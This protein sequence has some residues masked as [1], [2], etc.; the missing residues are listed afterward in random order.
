MQGGG[1]IVRLCTS[2]NSFIEYSVGGCLG[3]NGQQPLLTYSGGSTP[4]ATFTTTLS[5]GLAT[6]NSLAA[7]VFSFRVRTGPFELDFLGAPNC[8]AWVFG[9]VATFVT[10]PGGTAS[11]PI[12]VPGNFTSCL[13]LWNR[14][15]V[16]DR[17]SGRLGITTSNFGRIL[18]RQLTIRTRSEH[19]LRRALARVK[20]ALDE[21]WAQHR[22]FGGRKRQ[23]I[24]GV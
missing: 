3:S 18:D 24:L 9:D 19:L 1:L 11:I 7:L 8:D 4:G 23:P 12:T 13:P 16:F 15:F 10:T 22:G 14:W 21:A 20:R 5:G 6:P 17:T 2:T